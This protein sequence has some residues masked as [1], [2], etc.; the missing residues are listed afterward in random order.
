MA[1]HNANNNNSMAIMTITN[2]TLTMTTMC[3]LMH[4]SLQSLHNYYNEQCIKW[5]TITM[6][7]NNKNNEIT[8]KNENNG[9]KQ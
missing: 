6:H 5:I 9:H 2:V 7:N 3:Y 4:H 1:I 8:I